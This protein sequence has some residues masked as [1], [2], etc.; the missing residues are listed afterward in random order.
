MKELVKMREFELH[1][2]LNFHDE[3]AVNVNTCTFNKA[4]L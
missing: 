4:H 1:A 3:L 2:V